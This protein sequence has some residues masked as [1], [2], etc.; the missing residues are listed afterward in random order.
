VVRNYTV[1][2]DETEIKLL[3][4]AVRQ[5]RNTFDIAAAQSRAAGEP[6]TAD[7]EPV[8]ELYNR[9]QQKLSAILPPQPPDKPFRIK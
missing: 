3:L 8:E 2:L 7:Y 4:V 9:L 5:V 1:E 6:I